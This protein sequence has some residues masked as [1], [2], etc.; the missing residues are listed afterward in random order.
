METFLT[1][2]YKPKL[3]L[4]ESQTK[5]RLTIS[6]KEIIDYAPTLGESFAD[7]P[8]EFLK[9]AEIAVEQV[10]NRT[11]ITVR[12]KDLPNVFNVRIRDVR[13]Q[14]LSKLINVQGQINTVSDVRPMIIRAVFECL[15]CTQTYDRLQLGKVLN[16]PKK[17]G[18]GSMSKLK[19]IEKEY[20]DTQRIIVEEL[21]ES[22]EG[23]E[24]PRKI[25]VVLTKGLT[26]PELD[27]YNAP[28]NQILINGILEERP[29]GKEEES[30]EREFLLIANHIEPLEQDYRDIDIGKKEL[31]EIK[32]LAGKKNILDLMVQSYAPDIF[33]HEMI[34]KA[35]IF[36]LF[37]GN[38]V[39][40]GEKLIR[41]GTSNVILIG[42][43]GTS[44]T[45]LVKFATL[46]APK[47]KY[48]SGTGAS[49]VG[50]T[51]SVIK[52]DFIGGWAL[53]A[54]I[55]VLAHNGLAVLDELDKIPQEERGKL[56]EALSENEININ[57]ANIHAKLKCETTR[58][59]HNRPSGR[60]FARKSCLSFR[61]T[62]HW[63]ERT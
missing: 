18:C 57:K 55:L 2:R 33:G 3:L 34:K 51:A 43:P 16:F 45:K 19:C 44:K 29:K 37:G 21:L 39:R 8:Q 11:D 9:A 28:G 7:H 42:E 38:A 4:L 14:H 41:K 47:S 59:F 54:G 60:I 61:N 26:N 53:Q 30:T 22:L 58:R 40:Q 12:I 50:L 5:D 49:S 32:E 46:I 24:Q 10:T 1:E 48:S 6:F 56:H 23:N 62:R 31:E 17:C 20:A 15:S 63:N 25:N 35:I 36:Q 13:S 27:R 52:D